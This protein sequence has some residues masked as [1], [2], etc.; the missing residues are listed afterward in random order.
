VSLPNI[1]AINKTGNVQF[2]YRFTKYD[3]DIE[4]GYS[5]LLD[6]NVDTDDLPVP[7]GYSTLTYSAAVLATLVPSAGPMHYY[8]LNDISSSNFN[9]VDLGSSAKTGTYTVHPSTITEP[10]AIINDATAA[11]VQVSNTVDMAVTFST[12]PTDTYTYTNNTAATSVMF[13]VYVPSTYLALG[14]IVYFHNSV[15]NTAQTYGFYINVSANAPT[16]QLCFH[17]LPGKYGNGVAELEFNKWHQVALTQVYSPGVG[18][19]TTK[20]Y[21]DGALLYTN[22]IE[23]IPFLLGANDITM[24][25]GGNDP[26]L[27]TNNDTIR[28]AEVAVWNGTLQDSEVSIL[29]TI[30]TVSQGIGSGGTATIIGANSGY[31]SIHVSNSVNMNPGTLM[32]VLTNPPQEVTVDHIIDS[33][34]VALVNP[35]L[36]SATVGGELIDINYIPPI[37][38]GS[39]NPYVLASWINPVDV[40]AFVEDWNYQLGRSTQTGVGAVQLKE[41]W[42]SQTVLNYFGA[43]ALLKCEARQY[44]PTEGLDS[45]WYTLFSALSNGPAILDKDANGT[46]GYTV[47]LSGVT[48]I[49]SFDLVNYDVAPDLIHVTRRTATLVYQD[50]NVTIYQLPRLDGNASVN[51]YYYNWATVPSVRIWTTGFTTSIHDIVKPDDIIPVT[52]AQG[53][54]QI[55]G[56]AGQLVIDTN[57]LQAPV[58]DLTIEAGF[59]LGNPSVVE[60]ELYRYATAEDI[61]Y[62]PVTAV[63]TVVLNGLNIQ[64]YIEFNNVLGNINVLENYQGRTVFFKTGAAKGRYFKIVKTPYVISGSTCRMYVKAVDDQIP[65]LTTLGILS[66]DILQVTDAN[67]IEDALLKVFA[68]AGFQAQNP[69]NAFYM[70]ILPPSIPVQVPPFTYRYQNGIKENDMINELMQFAQPNYFVVENADGSITT[71]TAVQKT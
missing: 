42:D 30:G 1:D 60:V 15:V 66:G 3:L 67:L 7:Y 16:A 12:D 65:E 24:T 43:N 18:A 40:T 71:V 49:C 31:T 50:A 17:P 51:M 26:F 21:V 20:L 47:G 9:A 69:G 45:G 13:W 34:H 14:S 35:G 29:Y 68:R 41:S 46:K 57:Y 63:N 44:N 19:A 33:T 4:L 39:T 5:Q 56:G 11:S 23:C 36:T 62:V 32:Y 64:D 59:G 2:Q 28:V 58:Y 38:Y 70:N 55:V 8:R 27:G 10:G 22:L 6:E 48:K 25:V 37:N 54:I 53:S 61:V 52:S